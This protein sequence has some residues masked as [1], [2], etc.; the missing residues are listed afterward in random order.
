M[1]IWLADPLF[2]GAMQSGGHLV[3]PFAAF[4]LTAIVGLE[5][6]VQGKVAGLRTQT[7]VGTSS[8]LIL[9]V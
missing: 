7:I 8:A 1:Q 9:L 3:E 6:T 5:R 4:G 2:G